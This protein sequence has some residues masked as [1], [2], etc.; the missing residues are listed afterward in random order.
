MENSCL[1]IVE[2]F[3]P[4]LPLMSLYNKTTALIRTAS[5]ISK[6]THKHQKAL[7]RKKL[8]LYLPILKRL[9]KMKKKPLYF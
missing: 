9:L 8:N 6:A 5:E 1:M 7:E 4:I 3:K 2:H